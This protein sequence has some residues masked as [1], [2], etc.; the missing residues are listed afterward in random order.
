MLPR[1][2]FFLLLTLPIQAQDEEACR[3]CELGRIYAPYLKDL[4]PPKKRKDIGNS[5][6]KIT[7][8]SPA[9]QQWFD[10]GLNLLHAF[11]EFEAY[12][13]FLQ[14]AKED[15]DCAMAYWGVCMSLP[16]KNPES[17]A[18][19]AA[20]LAK[21]KELASNEDTKV[22]EHEKLYIG[23]VESLVNGGTGAAIP[24]LRL[25]QKK[26]PNDAEATAF[27]ALWLRDGYS[28]AGKPKTGTKEA[29]S[30]LEKALKKNKKWGSKVR[31]SRVR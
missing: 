13:C 18:E 20:A 27:L 15:P 29:I 5:H 24:A 26:F 19:R 3:C 25:I 23:V 14:A 11:W 1:L 10:Q 9:A 30:L 22:T 17:A 6:L 31:G 12:R 2:V 16:G 8:K 7:T 28:P 21:A 4:P